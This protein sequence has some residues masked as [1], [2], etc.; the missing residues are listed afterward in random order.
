MSCSQ[1]L[2]DFLEFKGTS[3]AI[4]RKGKYFPGVRETLI[5]CARELDKL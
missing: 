1:G 5:I 3:L 4:L 2:V